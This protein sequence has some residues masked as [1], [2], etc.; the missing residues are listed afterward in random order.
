MHIRFHA[1][2]S[3]H[4]RLS[5]SLSLNASLPWIRIKFLVFAEWKKKKKERKR[6]KKGKEKNAAPS[7]I[8]RPFVKNYTSPT[9][10]FKS[11]SFSPP[12]FSPPL[13]SRLFLFFP[14]FSIFPNHGRRRENFLSVSLSS[15]SQLLNLA[16]GKKIP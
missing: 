16:S 10:D 2:P 14:V 11:A 5:L 12:L 7:T 13:F 1:S 3:S 4:A 15:S 8:H 6:G 9:Y